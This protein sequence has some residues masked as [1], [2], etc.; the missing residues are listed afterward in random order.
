MARRR[1]HRRD[2]FPLLIDHQAWM[3]FMSECVWI[4]GIT[5]SII[6]GTGFGIEILRLLTWAAFRIMGEV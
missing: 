5:V 6:A 2:G 4:I 1:A 3:E